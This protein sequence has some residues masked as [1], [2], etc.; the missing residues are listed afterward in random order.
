MSKK[1]RYFPYFCQTKNVLNCVDLKSVYDYMSLYFVVYIKM[2]LGTALFNIKFQRGSRVFLHGVS[3]ATENSISLSFV[4]IKKSLNV[5]AQKVPWWLF[6]IHFS[7]PLMYKPRLSRSVLVFF[8]RAKA[9]PCF[10]SI[11]SVL[12]LWRAVSAQALD[13]VF[14]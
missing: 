4:A 13:N 3:P 5:C 9:Q 14:I 7:A 8:S 10:Q 6:L 12:V 11:Q 1:K 2:T